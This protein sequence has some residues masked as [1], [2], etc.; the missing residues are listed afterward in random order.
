MFAI[1]WCVFLLSALDPSPS[2]VAD[3]DMGEQIR[4]RGSRSAT[5]GQVSSPRSG[6]KWAGE[7]SALYNGSAG[8]DGGERKG[9][10]P[11]SV[12]CERR[13]GSAPFRASRGKQRSARRETVKVT[14]FGA[15][16]DGSEA[17]KVNAQAFN[18]A[19]ASLEQGGV[20][21][22][23]AGVY[24]VGGYD[25]R[26]TLASN[27]TLRG[28]GGEH[29]AELKAPSQGGSR[30]ILIPK[31]ARNVTVENLK[32]D[33]RSAED[34]DSAI[35][36]YGQESRIRNNDIYDS[37]YYLPSDHPAYTGDENWTRHA[38]VNYGSGLRVY[39]N[40]F[41]GV[42]VTLATGKSRVRDVEMWN[43][44]S[45]DSQAYAISATMKNHGAGFE[46]IHIHDNYLYNFTRG[47][48]YIGGDKGKP[49][50]PDRRL[51]NITVENN[52]VIIGPKLQK[53][54]RAIFLRAMGPSRDIRIHGN[55][56][57][58]TEQ[59]QGRG[60]GNLSLIRADAGKSSTF[61]QLTITDNEFAANDRVNYV[62]WIRRGAAEHLVIA[63]NEAVTD[64]RGIQIENRNEN[65]R[66]FKNDITT[67]AWTLS[68][69]GVNELSVSNNTFISRPEEK[70][71]RAIVLKS[72]AGMSG[73]VVGN[74]IEGRGRVPLAAAVAFKGVPRTN[75]RIEDND[76]FGHVLQRI[77]Q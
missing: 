70:G 59:A 16:G 17:P 26:I 19:I 40:E 44:R 3:D 10:R 27:V 72:G 32:M 29:A 60:A 14:S 42:Q 20:V 9:P 22:V 25:T 15:K 43:N 12:V 21:E 57:K 66:I 5:V 50:N 62:I 35:G 36:V 34:F 73:E 8:G 58:C 45:I 67:Q 30:M 4:S 77:A 1:V 13:A 6:R 63:G 49:L 53:F 71:R 76:V 74:R 31:E 55:V 33:I 38:I 75:V 2:A 65:V 37:T 47:G 69:A 24:V 7:A 39:G 28:I 51:S 18:E 64:G 48:I 68:I 41:H 23:P 11:L 61:K 56:V 52:E 54:Y 46:D